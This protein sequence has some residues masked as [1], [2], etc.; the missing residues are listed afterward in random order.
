MI[1]LILDLTID[2]EFQ[3]KIPPLSDA[4]YKQLEENILSAGEV[5]E[6]IT[7]WNDTIIDGHN[8][9]KIILN[10]PEL[11]WR[12]REMQ[13]EDKWQAFD[14]MYKNQLGRR[15]L[16]DEQRRYLLGKL[17]ESRKHVH[18]ETQIRDEDGT[19]RRR[20]NGANGGRV[21]EQI[22]N[23]QGVGQKTVERSEY[24]AHGIDAIREAEPALAESIL[25][26]ETKVSKVAIQDIGLAKPEY[27]PEMIQAVKD[28]TPIT[29]KEIEER[30]EEERES[31]AD[32][33]KRREDMKAIREAANELFK[34][35][36][37][38]YN[39]DSL[40]KDIENNASPFVR[41]FRQIVEGNKGLCAAN[42]ETVTTTIHTNIILKIEELEK[43]ILSYE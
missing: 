4:E 3:N 36:T 41:L 42:K 43:E 14:W 13:F 39:I 22:M 29:A 18:G 2:P 21:R 33:R 17:Y 15:N 20:Q 38:E 27:R 30:K 19:F 8:R 26:A 1:Y 28:G 31:K 12:T 40:L 32:K 37:A 5:Y 35:I 9:Y 23:E 16:T 24:Y 34:P 10:H 6:P 7:V 25:K 11:K